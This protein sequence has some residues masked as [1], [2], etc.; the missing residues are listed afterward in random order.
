MLKLARRSK[1][2]LKFLIIAYALIC[3]FM[4]VFQ[5]HLMYMPMTDIQA[6][7]AYGL[8]DFANLRLTS[9]DG[10]HLL[11]WYHKA[12]PGYPTIVYFHG[13][14]GNLA[15]RAS[16]FRL[17]SEAGFGVFGLDYRGYGAS[18]G[19]PSEEGFY[20]DAHAAMDYVRGTL[21]LAANQIIIYGES[22]GTG[23]AVQ[24]A[25]EYPSAALILQSP[26]T[27]L[28]AIAW[29]NYPWLPVHLLLKDRFDSLSKIANVHMP[30]LFFHGEQDNIVPIAAGKTLFAHA[31]EPK[32]AVYYSDSGHNNLNN[33]L[34]TKE[35]IA[36]C[37]KYKLIHGG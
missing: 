35:V 21:S 8:H 6:P 32:E 3:L 20:Q 27:S 5:R 33:E 23:V 17:L 36:F 18:E 37:N 28:E 2:I 31:L 9:K 7:G 12:K 1:A 13:N 4:W 14:G 22:I 15:N 26:F 11:A 10:T 34:L 16:Y 24:I 29:D 25:S 19:S 30:L